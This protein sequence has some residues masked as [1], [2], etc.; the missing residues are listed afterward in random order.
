MCCRVL[1]FQN[2][3][4]KDNSS[5]LK[6]PWRYVR[7]TIGLIRY[8][9]SY[10]LM[11]NTMWECNKNLNKVLEFNKTRG[12]R[13]WKIEM[14][15]CTQSLRHPMCHAFLVVLAAKAHLNHKS[16][17]KTQS[18]ALTVLEGRKR[19]FVGTTVRERWEKDPTA[20]DRILLYLHYVQVFKTAKPSIL[21][22]G[23]V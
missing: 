11:Q 4:R 10:M 6:R 12:C 15:H 18:S 9:I 13:F 8:G 5:S 7:C 1:M 19:V 23:D 17:K 3:I 2:S 20:Y 14:C 22:L 21:P 16:R